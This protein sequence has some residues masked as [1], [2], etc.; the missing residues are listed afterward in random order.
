MNFCTKEN[1]R[2]TSQSSHS[3]PLT[4]LSVKLAVLQH[5]HADSDSKNS[6]APQTFTDQRG[7][8]ARKSPVLRR[9]LSNAPHNATRLRL[10][11]FRVHFGDRGRSVAQHHAGGFKPEFL[12][13]PRRCIMPQLMRVP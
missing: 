2:A 8:T 3:N 7:R 12:A 5:H 4:D 13:Q 1:V 6:S 11:H 9:I 10:I